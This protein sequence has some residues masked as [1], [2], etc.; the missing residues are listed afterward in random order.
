MHVLTKRCNSRDQFV[1]SPTIPLVSCFRRGQSSPPP[2]HQSAPICPSGD[3]LW[4]AVSLLR[5]LWKQWIQFSR[6]HQGS[7]VT[8]A[9]R[10]T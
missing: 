3:G 6:G 10:Q 4:L 8:S 1:C 9:R 5:R 2:A 7:R